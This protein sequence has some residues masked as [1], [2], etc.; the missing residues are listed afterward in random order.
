[1]PIKTFNIL[2]GQGSQPGH[3]FTLPGSENVACYARPRT[4][5]T[6]GIATPNAF[7]WGGSLV[8]LDVKGEIFAAT[9]G[10]RKDTLGQEVIVLDPAAADFRT[11]RWNPL[12]VIERESP[13]RFDQIR[14]LSFSLWP[15]ATAYSSASS[16]AD[17]FW[18][19]SGRS[20][21]EGVTTLI[22]ETL[23]MPL[24]MTAIRRMFT[25]ADSHEHLAKMIENRRKDKDKR[26]YSRDA[27]EQV[28]DYLRGEIQQVEG[29]RKTVTTKLAPW[30]S[31][32]M[33][34]ATEKSDFDLRQLRR[35]KMSIYL[36]VAP[37][38]IP[39]YRS[40]IS[41]FL[42]QML[43]LN[44]DVLPEHDETIQWQTLLLL[45][46]FLRVGRIPELAEAGQYL[47]GYGLR[48][49][50]IVQDKA[51]LAAKYGEDAMADI[52]SNVGAEVV[53]GV[54]DLKTTTELSERIGY[55]TVP[56]ATEN[57]P[58]WW[59]ALR[60]ERQTTATAPNRRAVMLPQEIARLPQDEMIVLRAGVMPARV[61]RL[62][63]FDDPYFKKLYRRPPEI[64]PIAVKVDPDDG[65]TPVPR[66]IPRRGDAHPD[67]A[68][69]AAASAPPAL[70]DP[71]S[72]KQGGNETRH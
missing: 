21:F 9:A 41:L 44:T 57:R 61:K 30:F 72:T 24:N 60:W 38:N 66:P 51:Q 8:C 28:A 7:E 36:T 33:Q 45:D 67:S 43:A 56:I 37:G 70:S 58:R 13:K 22:A 11:H 71:A 1:V 46:E 48:T 29:I 17:R 5:K 55:N 31:P 65:Q 10:H 2:L 25:A 53:F 49:L 32:Q 23:D 64:P 42:E 15:D 54:N 63:W 39:R 40:Y 19:P 4:G 62:R 35:K 3:F 59:G 16:N 34:A 14:R 6:V 27:V 52:F 18:D 50:M 12:A 47:T 26:P 69:P 68:V 20:A